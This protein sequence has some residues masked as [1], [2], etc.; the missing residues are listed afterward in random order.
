MKKNLLVSKGIVL[1]FCLLSNNY[2]KAQSG[3]VQIIHNIADPTA[4]SVAIWVIEGQTATKKFD[5]VNFR[6][7][8][9][10]WEYTPNVPIKFAISPAGASSVADTIPG[11]STELTMTPDSGY[12]IMAIGNLGTGFASNPN[13]INTKARLMVIENAK[14]SP[15]N[16]SNFRFTF[17]NGG[18]DAPTMNLFNES[19]NKEWANSI[20]FANASEYISTAP[21]NYRIFIQ[22]SSTKNVLQTFV[23]NLGWGQRNG[24]IFTAGYLNPSANNN[25]SK[26]E[27]FVNVD[28]LVIPTTEVTTTSIIEAIKSNKISSYPNPTKNKLLIDIGLY[29]ASPITIEVFDNTGKKVNS[30]VLQGVK[31]KNTIEVNTT[32]F[33]N[34]MYYYTLKTKDGINT[35][36]FAVS[37]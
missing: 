11:L 3:F 29:E 9:G 32:S 2:S 33:S 34:G 4:S 6:A 10:F 5:N 1:L 7:A 20:S 31:G 25:G 22:D 21:Q 27:V 36:R 19:G 26:L 12:I 35:S 16:G 15:P 13:G 37:K 28:N 8:T 14:I 24:I 18:T 17:I 30:Q 23:S